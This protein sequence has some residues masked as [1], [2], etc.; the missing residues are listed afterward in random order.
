M[1]VQQ[2]MNRAVYWAGDFAHG[3]LHGG[4]LENGTRVLPRGNWARTRVVGVI[5]GRRIYG[6]VR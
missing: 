5:L 4:G 2:S 6:L 3:R 1:N